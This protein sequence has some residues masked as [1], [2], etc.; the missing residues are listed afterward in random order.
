M[1][2]IFFLMMFFNVMIYSAGLKSG[3]YKAEHDYSRFPE[4]TYFIEKIVSCENLGEN[5]IMRRYKCGDLKV[6]KDGKTVFLMVK[7][8]LDTGNF[9]YINKGDYLAGLVEEEDGTYYGKTDLAEF[10]IKKINNN[11]LELSVISRI[12]YSATE[13]PVRA[14]AYVPERNDKMTFKYK[15]KVTG[16]DEKESAEAAGS[17]METAKEL[18]INYG[19][20]KKLE[21]EIY[22]ADKKVENA[23][24]DSFEIYETNN[25]FTLVFSDY[26]KDKNNVYYAGKLWKEADYKSFEYLGE[27]YAKDG[28]NIYYSGKKING[29]DIGTFEI[30]NWAY[31]K[32]KKNVYLK[33]E[34]VKGENPAKFKL[35]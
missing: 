28:N 4:N 17:F 15:G 31:A 19:N 35:Q 7:S 21:N 5:E 11:E 13:F 30:I 16:N 18:G 1:K 14:G 2:K 33:G 25:Y 27:S 26:A 24:F 3:L 6:F 29:A 10:F 23:D 12:K 8:Y 32:D 9:V 20:Y 22:Y 34:I